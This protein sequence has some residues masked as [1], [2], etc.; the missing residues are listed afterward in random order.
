MTQSTLYDSIT[1]CINSG[2]IGSF[3]CDTSDIGSIGT[4]FNE[5]MQD[6]Y[7]NNIAPSNMEYVQV[8]FKNSQ[9]IYTYRT[10]IKLIVGG[11][12]KIIA[13]NTTTYDNPVTII[14]YTHKNEAPYIRTITKATLIKGPDRPDDGI[15]D[16][17]INS[18]KR[19]V[20]VAWKDGSKTKVKCHE[21]DNFD[22]EKGIAL[23]Y[24]KKK[25]NNRGC[26]NEV[27][28]KYIKD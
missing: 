7:K 10:N 16:V 19:T 9:K 2:G 5:Y 24:M 18:E 3:F 8:K 20:V 13:D 15:K 11:V 27:F 1:T 6:E 21:D 12:Y 22:A 26:Y 17:Y 23:C 14:G 4:N 28:K 25:F